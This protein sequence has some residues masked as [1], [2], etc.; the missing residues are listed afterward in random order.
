[1]ARAIGQKARMLRRLILA[2]VA[3]L[4]IAAPACLL[5]GAVPAQAAVTATF[6]SHKF[7]LVD[8]LRTDFPHGFVVLAGRDQ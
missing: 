8:G 1:M 5:F 6:Y 3:L 2:L 4:A 7:R